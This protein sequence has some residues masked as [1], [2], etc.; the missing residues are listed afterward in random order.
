V[1]AGN[2]RCPSYKANGQSCSLTSMRISRAVRSFTNIVRLFSPSEPK[3]ELGRS[4]KQQLAQTL[5]F[6]TE[7]TQLVRRH[8]VP[9]VVAR[10]GKG[11]S[12]SSRSLDARIN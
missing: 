12:M 2:A 10:D 1:Y 5:T 11:H 3:L 7:G 9:L 4:G 6:A 8:F